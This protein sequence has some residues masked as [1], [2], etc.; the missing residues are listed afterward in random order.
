MSELDWHDV[1]SDQAPAEPRPVPPKAPIAPTSDT[2]CQA[3]RARVLRHPEI[4]KR[5]CDPPL[6]YSHPEAW[7]GYVPP[8]TWQGKTNNHPARA[9]LLGIITAAVEAD[10][11]GL[12]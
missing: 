1:D 5:L 7:S 2:A 11:E 3:E 8:E 4:A 12:S 9:A 6:R 10:K